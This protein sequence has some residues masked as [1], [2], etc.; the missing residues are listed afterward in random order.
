MLNTKTPEESLEG[1]ARHEEEEEASDPIWTNFNKISKAFGTDLRGQC[2]L[3]N[4]VLD[5]ILTGKFYYHS[6]YMFEKISLEDL[7]KG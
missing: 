4:K 2:Q 6:N 3:L 5:E 7:H 1:T